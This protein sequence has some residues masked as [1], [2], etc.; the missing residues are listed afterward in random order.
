MPLAAQVQEVFAIAT[1]EGL[2]TPTRV[3]QCVSNA[4]GYFQG[5]MTGMLARLNCKVWVDDI[6][7]WE[8]DEDNLLNTL[9]K[10]LG[11]LEDAGLFV[12]A[13]KCL[14]FIPKSRGVERCTQGDI[15]LTA[16]SI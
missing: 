3:P 13:H 6:G 1:P 9:D 16:G 10:I 14:F 7:W 11:R 2:F 4:T 15:C 8:A 12:A 5:V